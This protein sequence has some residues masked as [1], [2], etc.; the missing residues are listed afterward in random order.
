MT[1]VWNERDLYEVDRV[2]SSLTKDGERYSGVRIASL[3]GKVVEIWKLPS[4]E[5]PEKRMELYV[6]MRRTEEGHLC[7]LWLQGNTQ[8]LAGG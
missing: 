8:S 1:H 6:C 7:R 2:A 4:Q 5:S 3:E